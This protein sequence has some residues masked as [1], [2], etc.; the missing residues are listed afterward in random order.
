M[1]LS[2]L[3]TKTNIV[4]TFAENFFV[5][6]IPINEE[7]KFYD[8]I[9]QEGDQTVFT[10]SDVGSRLPAE[11]K[12]VGGI[13]AR[14]YVKKI[15]D[16]KFQ[17]AGVLFN[18]RK[19]WVWDLNDPA[20]QQK[21]LG[22]KISKEREQLLKQYLAQKL[23]E[24]TLTAGRPEKIDNIFSYVKSKLGKPKSDAEV[25][26]EAPVPS[27]E[28]Q[29]SSDQPGFSPSMADQLSDT[30]SE[31]DPS[32]RSKGSK[33]SDPVQVEPYT[34]RQRNYEQEFD[35]VASPAAKSDKAADIPTDDEPVDSVPDDEVPVDDMLDDETPA[36]G[37]QPVD[38]PAD[39][40]AMPSMAGQD[41]DKPDESSLSDKVDSA[42]QQPDEFDDVPGYQK[43]GITGSLSEARKELL[44]RISDGEPI[45]VNLK[46]VNEVYDN[47]PWGTR[48]DETSSKKIALA[49]M[50]A[51]GV[52]WLKSIG[53]KPV[54]YLGIPLEKYYYSN[55]IIHNKIG[56]M[57]YGQ[58]SSP[59][60]YS[61]VK[62]YRRGIRSEES[63]E[64]VDAHFPDL[65][66]L[67]SYLHRTN[68]YTVPKPPEPEAP[69]PAPETRAPAPAPAPAPKPPVAKPPAAK[70]PVAKPKP[71][72]PTAPEKPIKLDVE[73]SDN[74]KQNFAEKAQNYITDLAKPDQAKLN[75][76]I[77]DAKRQLDGSYQMPEP[78]GFAN[79]SM[80]A[81][82][83]K[84]MKNINAWAKKNFGIEEDLVKH[85]AAEKRIKINFP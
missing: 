39:P 7:T 40:V 37:E 53:Y 63:Y 14:V 1:K 8:H 46:E 52:E 9:V 71:A 6:D 19:A 83:M 35:D 72:E 77:K 49:P 84:G 67:Q 11:S 27:P 25:T 56:F 85:N 36:D 48:L 28:Q 80:K 65:Y 32:F 43:A 2:N 82:Y 34:A 78:S 17:I 18:L 45:Q 74:K 69:T 66:S 58:I 16:K 3:H 60:H 64:Q 51:D 13:S 22:G 4:L 81:V 20:Q 44:Q 50:P 31:L 42:T 62:D 70:P 21:P 26:P 55:R 23:K 15:D 79:P 33:E 59:S 30:P 75:N 38:E 29:V 68:R 12:Y 41:D 24:G 57:S 61:L 76:L 5:G 47:S 10:F 73:S 54:V